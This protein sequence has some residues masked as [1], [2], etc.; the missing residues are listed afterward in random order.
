M[1]FSTAYRF[2][3]EVNTFQRGDV[4]ETVKKVKEDRLSVH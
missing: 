2:Y 4:G 1:R 3:R